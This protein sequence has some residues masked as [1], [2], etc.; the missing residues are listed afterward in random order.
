MNLTAL[1]VSVYPPVSLPPLARRC[2]TPENKT[3]A[4]RKGPV[5]SPATE[6]MDQLPSN[7]GRKR[8]ADRAADT[9]DPKRPSA[10]YKHPSDNESYDVTAA[11]PRHSS[12]T[13]ER[14]R[15]RYPSQSLHPPQ[16]V[17][18]PASEMHQPRRPRSPNSNAPDVSSHR[19]RSSRSASMPQRTML[20]NAWRTV[21]DSDPLAESDEEFPDEHTR[22]DYTRRIRVISRL[23]GRSPTPAESKSAA[24]N[25]QSTTTPR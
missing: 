17:H 12:Y 20:Q 18:R 22:L 7:G 5:Y 14:Q 11:H 4:K 9:E 6:D 15:Q 1:A 8:K 13:A 2:M 21:L 16:P 23:R 25:H 24:N 19:P 3:P 10:G